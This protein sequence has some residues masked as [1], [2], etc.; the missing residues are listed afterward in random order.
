MTDKFTVSNALTL[1]TK[2]PTYIC[3]VHG[4]VVGMGTV[5]LWVE[6]EITSQHCMKCYHEWILKNIPKVGFKK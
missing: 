3:P 2:P 5:A 4:E 1:S 6:N